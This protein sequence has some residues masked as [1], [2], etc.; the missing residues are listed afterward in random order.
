[1]VFL[2]VFF[3]VNFLTCEKSP[4]VW[5]D[6]VMYADPAVNWYQGRGFTSGAWYQ[7]SP[8]AFWAGNVPLYEF[9]LFGWLK[10]AGF[11]LVI[12][13]CFHYVAITG[14]LVLLWLALWR[15]DLIRSG[16]GRLA[17]CALLGCC[18]SVTFVF[19]SARPESLSLLLVGMV[20]CACTLPSRP[21]RLA[22][23]FLLG[24]LLLWSG[25]QMAAYLLVMAAVIWIWTFG[26]ACQESLSLGLGI[27]AGVLLLYWFYSSHHVWR[28]FLASIAHHTIA[29]AATSAGADN[30]IKGYGNL[31]RKLHQLPSLYFNYSFVPVFLLTGRFAMEKIARGWFHVALVTGIWHRSVC[32]GPGG[33]V[34]GGCLS[35]LLLLDGFPAAGHRC[36]P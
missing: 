24:M 12:V 14:A 21:L 18:S 5:Q 29:W 20:L 16:R 15:L 30:P 31:S 19:R 23:L 11:S 36:L 32:G 7:Q 6:E 2:A 33:A 34:R 8:D 22:G 28:E 3:A 9:V 13:R 10:A 1:M 35:H 27:G 17:F 25:L 4:T 26:M